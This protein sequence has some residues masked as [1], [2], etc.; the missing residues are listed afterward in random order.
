MLLFK[1]QHVEPILNG[2]K[3][4]TRRIWG[5]PRAKEGS[6]HLA[7]TKMLSKEYFAKIFINR[8]FR[9]KL[10][11]MTEEDALAEGYPSREAYYDAFCRINKLTGT[12][13]GYGLLCPENFLD[14]EVWVV[15]F[16]VI[17]DE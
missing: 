16:K 8:V 5:R 12:K 2:T 7:K 4:Q 6:I 3:W 9:Q 15:H 17:K 13:T 10:R 14:M 11:D 1:P